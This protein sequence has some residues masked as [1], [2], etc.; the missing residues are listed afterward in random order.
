[1][2]LFH[3]SVPWV[4]SM[5]L[6]HESVPW[7]CSMSLFHDSVLLWMTYFDFKTANFAERWQV[8]RYVHCEIAKS[9]FCI[10]LMPTHPWVDRTA[11]LGR[12][13]AGGPC[14]QFELWCLRPTCPTKGCWAE[15]QT[16]R[17]AQHLSLPRWLTAITQ[18]ATMSWMYFKVVYI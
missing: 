9:I 5:I 6:F 10:P 12:G 2:S 11:W 14:P 16:A 7:F 17:G 13:R 3:D 8:C 1:M 18:M 15:P 4:C